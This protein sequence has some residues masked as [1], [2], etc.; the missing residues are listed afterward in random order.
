M[1]RYKPATR[2]HQERRVIS[3][4][5]AQC[6]ASIVTTGRDVTEARM[7]AY[8]RGWRSGTAAGIDRSLDTCPKCSQRWLVPRGTKEEDVPDNAEETAIAP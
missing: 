7:Q 4:D 2:V 5:L 3:C 8:V 6:G 1:I